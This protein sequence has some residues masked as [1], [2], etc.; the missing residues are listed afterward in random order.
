M[1]KAP[2]YTAKL[3]ENAKKDKLTL[4]C[5][6]I[7]GRPAKTS[8]RATFHFAIEHSDAER[9]LD[10]VVALFSAWCAKGGK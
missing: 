6:D 8:G 7:D 2:T 4:I 1:N 3:R 10:E 5:F 9:L